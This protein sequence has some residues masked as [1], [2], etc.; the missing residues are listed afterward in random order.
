M[1][2]KYPKTHNVLN[3]KIAPYIPPLFYETRFVYDFKKAAKV[4][5]PFLEKQF[6]VI[7]NSSSLPSEFLLKTIK[8]V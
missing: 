6:T 1:I 5:N 8:S 2:L 3:N 7:N 4:F